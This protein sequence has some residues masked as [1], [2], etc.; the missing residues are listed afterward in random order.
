LPSPAAPHASPAAPPSGWRSAFRELVRSD[1]W[2]HALGALLLACAALYF[3]PILSESGRA[4]LSTHYA[5]PVFLF[6]CLGAL[7]AGRHQ[8]AESEERRFWRDLTLAFLA[9]AAATPLYFLPEISTWLHIETSIAVNVFYT[10]YYLGWVLAAERRPDQHYR[11]RPTELEHA[12][13]WP[14]VTTFIVGLMAY[15]WLV[16]VVLDRELFESWLP[17][18][19]LFLALDVYLSARFFYLHRQARTVRWRTI[20]AL[21]AATTSAYLLSDLLELA[22]YAGWVGGDWGQGR[23]VVWLVPYALFVVAVRL[24]HCSFGAE[25]RAQDPPRGHWQS[26]P[27]PAGRTLIFAL[28]LPTF[29]FTASALE[30][31]SRSVVAQARELVVLIW[32]LLLGAI[33]YFQHRVLERRARELWLERL[34]VEK[35]LRKTEDSMRLNLERSQAK[36]AIHASEEKF[37][38]IFHSSPAAMGIATLEDGKII[39]VNQGY[40]R[41]TGYSRR[42]VVGRTV[43]KLDLWWEP[44]GRE[45]MLRE[46]RERGSI[47]NLQMALRDKEGKRR[48]VAFAVE[49]VEIENRECLLSVLLAVNDPQALKERARRRAAL[50]D[51]ARGAVWVHDKSGRIRYW[52]PGAERLFGWPAEEVARR[53][54][55]EL[56]GPVEIVPGTCTVEHWPARGGGELSVAVRAVAVAGPRRGLRSTLVF[57]VE[58]GQK[59]ESAAERALGA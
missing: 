49:T 39:D 32:M 27:S 30:P 51:R 15:F 36:E 8:I 25:S 46:L 34:G 43:A 16:P 10:V 48:E 13:V 6:L 7:L 45:V 53:R 50:L 14:S 52:S 20:Y 4:R 38:K 29:H 18:M 41:F 3:L 21:L 19:H 56:F 37:F 5:P 35:A 17:S 58:A 55:A 47:E 24:R 57:C 59:S 9:W 23:D 22:M 28:A 44:S 31:E 26:L 1:P 12:V 2:A 42:E 40:E 54:L 11:F 33:A